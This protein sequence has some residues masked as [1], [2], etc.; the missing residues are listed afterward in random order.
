MKLQRL[1]DSL[2]SPTFCETLRI[3]NIEKII[4]KLEE[5]NSMI[6]MDDVKNSFVSQ[7]LLIL[8]MR[9]RGFSPPFKK[10]HTVLSGPPGVG[11]TSMSI[12][13][14]EIWDALHIMD[15]TSPTVA[16]TP[17]MVSPLASSIMVV[18][19]D[20]KSVP[21]RDLSKIITEVQDKITEIMLVID[22]EHGE[23]DSEHIPDYIKTIYSKSQS[24]IDLCQEIIEYYSKFFPEMEEVS[25]I[26]H[27][28]CDS[29][30]ETVLVSSPKLCSLRKLASP[31]KPV[32]PAPKPYVVLG[33]A[34]FVGSYQGKT[35]EKTEAI[36]KK[37][38]GKVIIIEE[39][40][41]LFTDEKDSY[42]MEAL[43][44]INR[45]MDEHCD[46]YIFIFNGYSDRLESS[47]FRAQP[48]LKRRIQWTFNVQ[49]YTGE[50]IFRIFLHQL[51]RYSNP[52]WRICTCDFDK[53]QHFFHENQKY[54]P[55][56]GGDTEKFILYAQLEYGEKFY[57]TS[58][59]NPEN[60]EIT[61]GIIEN[62]F[63]RYKTLNAGIIQEI[64]RIESLNESLSR[65]TM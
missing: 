48:G 59:G 45:Y 10:M 34:D 23:T 62:A 33:R 17:Y 53:V 39:A 12:L 61:Y 18:A 27:S 56:Y 32:A 54:F 9:R 31:M 36:L 63:K 64:E 7:L 5:M 65:M 19:S 55:Y 21:K 14:A 26:T 28:D 35:S 57:Y 46:D 40:Y 30:A 2:K 51:Q 50:G 47:I 43:T 58:D 4:L 38:K 15:K 41:A 11:K 24:S 42:G 20:K 8:T 6:E 49:K 44:I 1:I 29:D 37:N 60:C 25:I 3:D 16:A 52:Y 22:K 13:I